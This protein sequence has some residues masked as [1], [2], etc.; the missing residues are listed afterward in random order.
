M[1][2]SLWR[3]TQKLQQRNKEFPYRCKCFVTLKEGEQQPRDG[4]RRN[5]G[6]GIE[7]NRDQPG[8]ALLHL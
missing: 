2:H 5:S 6:P 4:L 1:V 7:G 3:V 8:P